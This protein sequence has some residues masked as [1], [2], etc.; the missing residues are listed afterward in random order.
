MVSTT[1][2]VARTHAA[3]SCMPAHACRLMH[4]GSVAKRGGGGVQIVGLLLYRKIRVGKHKEH[5]QV[6]HETE[7]Y[8]TQK[9][10]NNRI[11]LTPRYG[12]IVYTYV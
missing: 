5:Q 12:N 6:L 4:A 8:F 1:H 11:T 9:T 2:A 7:E 3:S 10:P